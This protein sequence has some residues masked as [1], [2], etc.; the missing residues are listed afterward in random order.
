MTEI[1]GNLKYTNTHE[2][3]KIEQDGTIK[4]GITEHAQ[5]MLGD[6]VFV[7]LPLLDQEISQGDECAVIESVKAAA[8][9]YAPISGK[10]ISVNASLSDAPQLI[11][12][13]S[14]GNGWIFT[15][16][17]DNEDEIA[18]LL[19]STQYEQQLAIEH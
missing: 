10:I 1:P 19:S 4:I 9:I 11:N 3:I 5:A 15:I 14:Y 2:W 18:S 12:E 7:D 13:D 6:V 17:P 16:Q 8:D